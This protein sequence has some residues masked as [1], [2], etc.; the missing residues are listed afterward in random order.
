MCKNVSEKVAVDYARQQINVD[1]GKG[2]F[3]NGHAVA[4]YD[5]SG[6]CVDIDIA[7]ENLIDDLKQGI[8]PATLG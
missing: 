4:S 7:L 3:E 8:M 2:Q 1:D 6:E 5:L